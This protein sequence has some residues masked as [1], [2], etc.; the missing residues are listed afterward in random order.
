MTQL[1]VPGHSAGPSVRDC[2]SLSLCQAWPKGELGEKREA[3][4]GTSQPG[5]QSPEQRGTG[6]EVVRRG[7]AALL[8]HCP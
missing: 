8:S 6:E 7:Q 4:Q 3:H 5:L 1:S 2:L